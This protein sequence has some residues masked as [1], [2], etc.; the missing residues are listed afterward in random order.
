[1]SEYYYSH[2]LYISELN[3]NSKYLSVVVL[4]TSVCI[5]DETSYTRVVHFAHF[6][7]T[8]YFRG[9][10]NASAVAKKQFRKLQRRR[11]VTVCQHKYAIEIGTV[12]ETAAH[13]AGT[14]GIPNR[15]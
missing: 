3:N 13:C 6:A 5:D 7:Q 11:F 15:T 12:A 4:Q 10:T 14:G 1:L 8:Y 9:D 2:R